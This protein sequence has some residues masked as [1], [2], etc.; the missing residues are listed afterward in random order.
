MGAL[1][2]V[3]LPF[4]FGKSFRG[5]V[6]PAMI[7][8]AGGPALALGGLY[9]AVWK[10]GGRPLRA[11]S[12]EGIGLLM[13]IVGLVFAIPLFGI[14]GAAVVSSIAY[15]AVALL[16]HWGRPVRTFLEQSQ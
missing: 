7:L 9:A 15:M 2:P 6:L 14:R 1:A 5:A 3:V 10:A 8:L 16:L 12:A 4:V 11:A 13:T